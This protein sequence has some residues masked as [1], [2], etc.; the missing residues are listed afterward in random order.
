MNKKIL[1]AIVMFFLIVIPLVSNMPRLEK[2]LF[3]NSTGPGAI[4]VAGIGLIFSLFTLL[5]MYMFYKEANMSKG[6]FASV[7]AYNLLIILVKAISPISVYDVNKNTAFDCTLFDNPLGFLMIAAG[8]FLLY[9]AVFFV[10]Y[11]VYKRKVNRSLSEKKPGHGL[12]NTII[13]ILGG[14]LLA[15][16]IITGG[17][18]GILIVLFVLGAGAINYLG[19]LSSTFISIVIGIALLGAIL[20]LKFAF[21]SSVEQ[22]IRLRNAGILATFFWIGAGFLFMYSALW[23]VYMMALVALWPLRTVCPK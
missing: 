13:G 19:I 2:A 21:D 4:T 12:R 22:A 11:L 14:I 9:F 5:I 16:L 6:F 18:A 1:A 23:V 17:S 3:P 8:V 10:F 15:A 7:L 20:F